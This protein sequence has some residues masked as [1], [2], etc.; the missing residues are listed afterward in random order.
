VNRCSQNARWVHALLK[1]YLDLCLR[2]LITDGRA[3]HRCATCLPAD[4]QTCA[5]SSKVMALSEP[6]GRSGCNDSRVHLQ[7]TA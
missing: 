3:S 2:V 1:P 5:Y 6:S 7:A 4:S